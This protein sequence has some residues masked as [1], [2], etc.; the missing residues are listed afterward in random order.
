MLCPTIWIIISSRKN[1][2][3]DTLI[4]TSIETCT[5]FGPS[6]PSHLLKPSLLRLIPSQ[7]TMF[8]ITMNQAQWDAWQTLGMSSSA[9][10]K[11][12][13]GGYGKG[14]GKG[15]NKAAGYG[16]GHYPTTPVA[17]TPPQT[18]PYGTT[19]IGAMPPKQPVK[20]GGNHWDPQAPAKGKGKG[21]GKDKT[22][23]RGKEKS[24]GDGKI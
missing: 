10:G 11:K 12:E 19:P 8:T 14:Q 16:K 9:K 1:P 4:T 13:K 5:P 21:C 15:K 3:L 6:K 2:D 22:K 23:G 24:K 20:G 18:S 7:S 17:Y